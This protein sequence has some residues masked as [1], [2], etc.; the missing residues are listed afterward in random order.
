MRKGVAELK[1]SLPTGPAGN[2]LAFLT[3]T[4]QTASSQ[5]AQPGEKSVNLWFN[6]DSAK[7]VHR[8][9]VTNNS[10]KVTDHVSYVAAVSA[11]MKRLNDAGLAQHQLALGDLMFTVAEA[12]F[13][14][15]PLAVSAFTT[16]MCLKAS[17]IPENDDAKDHL[18]EW[19]HF[20][21]VPEAVNLPDGEAGEV[22][23]KVSC[24]CCLRVV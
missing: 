21:C 18:P 13:E 2:V 22:P 5:Q 7:S 17:A 10:N 11:V 24:C 23:C 12:I 3:E 1:A 14:N 4:L 9:V 19:S 16:A 8:W 6:S 15:V 20:L